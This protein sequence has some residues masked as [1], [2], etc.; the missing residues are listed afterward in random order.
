MELEILAFLVLATA[1][2]AGAIIT[3]WSRYVVHSAFGLML[4]LLAV[5]G[6]YVLLGSDF[7]AV[8]QV[9]VYVGGVV[10]LYLFGVMLTPPDLGERSLLRVGICGAFGLIA[11]VV[12]VGASYGLDLERVSGL[13]VT[14]GGT[15]RGTLIK[16]VG[17]QFMNRTDYLLAFELASVLLL[18]ALVGA[19]FIARRRGEAAR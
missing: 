7:L 11:L 10:V 14:A 12:L 15:P 8:T 2:I 5:A 9:V 1:A 18:V 16:D 4:T 13:D 3:L 6:F 19:V 17:R